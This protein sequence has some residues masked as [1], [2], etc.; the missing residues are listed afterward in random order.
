MS[1]NR[2]TIRN[3]LMQNAIDLKPGDIIVRNNFVRTVT[4]VSYNPVTEEVSVSCDYIN[5]YG[6]SSEVIKMS[7]H[8]LVKPLE[9]AR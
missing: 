4:G 2:G 6:E 8:E 3:L 7:A 9:V 1:T 5:A